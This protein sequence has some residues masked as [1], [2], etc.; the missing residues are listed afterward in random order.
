[1]PGATV[2]N[3]VVFTQV[4][5]ALEDDETTSRTVDAVLREGA[6]WISGSRWHDRA[7]L[8][9]SMSNWSTTPADVV[10]AVDA[11]RRARA[12]LT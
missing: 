6:V 2:L 3:D 8:R 9:A 7:V 4:T 10:A 1:M 12:S 5:A 11:V